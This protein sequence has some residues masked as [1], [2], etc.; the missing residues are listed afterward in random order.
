MRK[1]LLCVFLLLGSGCPGFGSEGAQVI[2]EVPSFD[3]EIKPIFDRLCNECHG[4]TPEQGGEL[5]PLRYDVCEDADLKGKATKG[6]KANSPRTQARFLDGGGMPPAKYAEQAT[7]DEIAIVQRWIDEGS[8][9]DDANNNSTNNGNN[10][11]TSGTNGKT[12]TG[13]EP[14][15]S[16][17]AEILRGSCT[18]SDGAC[19]QNDA[20]GLQITKNDA[21]ATLAA[22]LQTDNL[23]GMAFVVPNDAAGSR[24]FIRMSDPAAPMPP[25]QLLSPAIIDQIEAWI[26]AGAKY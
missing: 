18:D 14:S 1:Y 3:K 13:S 10:S 8:P 5:F 6:A 7:P 23:Q 12:T 16:D 21:T 24:L 4:A 26:N 20:G 25:A 17:V 22:E 11:T 2:D 19:H 15:F 9:C